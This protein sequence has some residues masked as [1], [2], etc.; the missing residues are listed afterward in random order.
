VGIRRIIFVV[1]FPIAVV[2]TTASG[3]LRARAGAGTRGPAQFEAIASPA[4][5]VPFA[6]TLEHTLEGVTSTGRYYRWADGSTC[7]V[8]NGKLGRT[9]HINDV[10]TRS[11]YNFVQ[12]RGWVSRPLGLAEG[13]YRPTRKFA[14]NT[15]GMTAM[16]DRE[17]FTVFDV[18]NPNGDRTTLAPG[19]NF[20][21][22]EQASS[23]G[24]LTKYSHIIVGEP[25]NDP[26][27][28]IPKIGEIT[29][30]M[31]TPGGIVQ[32]HKPKQ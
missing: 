7:S 19:L 14:K 9:V 4:D 26:A 25:P 1:A 3:V 28:S 5:W 12:S 15:P 24:G 22:V 23:D 17:G 6:A 18:I 29:G 16:Y 32:Q 8:V 10:K 21:H 2:V 11:A 31:T 27:C 20:F 30:R 13:P